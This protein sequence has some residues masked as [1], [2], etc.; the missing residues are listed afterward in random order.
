GFLDSSV[1]IDI[2]LPDS[3]WAT[4][5][6]TL[7]MSLYLSGTGSF[8]LVPVGG[9]SEMPLTSNW[10]HPSWGGDFLPGQREISGSG[11]QAQWQT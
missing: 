5:I 4:R 10:P 6:L 8:S 11:W 9:S 3:Q 7:A 1:C 2:R